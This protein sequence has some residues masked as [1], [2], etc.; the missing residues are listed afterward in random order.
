MLELRRQIW[1]RRRWPMPGPN[2]QLHVDKRR[3]AQKTALS[4]FL[5]TAPGALDGSKIRMISQNDTYCWMVLVAI[6]LAPSC[7]RKNSRYP[8]KICTKFQWTPN[9]YYKK[10]IWIRKHIELNIAMTGH[11]DVWQIC[12][13]ISEQN[14]ALKSVMLNEECIEIRSWSN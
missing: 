2:A 7:V 12:W 6:D 14:G 8:L 13:D 9:A 10:F 5:H 11:W 1:R 4:I 3:R